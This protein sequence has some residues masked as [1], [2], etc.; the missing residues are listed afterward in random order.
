MLYSGCRL[1]RSS[2]IKAD[3]SNRQQFRYRKNET[4]P[5]ERSK[6]PYLLCS[7]YDSTCNDI[8]LHDTPWPQKHRSMI[9]LLLFKK[10][11]YQTSICVPLPNCCLPNILTRIALTWLSS[12]RI[13][14][15]STTYPQLDV[16]N[17]DK[18]QATC[19]FTLGA[20]SI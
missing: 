15:A 13:L 4:H 3:H 11:S 9:L 5:Q 14:K 18:S 16:K 8:T 10:K 17:T 7:F 12:V 2:Q 1:G 6:E 20:F 19:M